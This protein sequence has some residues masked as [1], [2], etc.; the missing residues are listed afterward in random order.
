ML[1]VEVVTGFLYHLTEAIVSGIHFEQ[2]EKPPDMLKAL[3]KPLTNV[4]VQIDK[5]V[6]KGWSIGNPK[7]EN[8]T[9][10]LKAKCKQEIQD[11]PHVI[12]VR[13]QETSNLKVECC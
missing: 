8:V 13:A 2:G 11:L 6:L 5:K 7:Y 4:V 3:T 1:V 9:T 10:L 12:V